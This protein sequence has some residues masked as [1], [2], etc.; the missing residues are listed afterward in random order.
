MSGKLVPKLRIVKC[1]K[2]RQLLQEP[3]GYDVYKCGGCGTDLQGEISILT[4]YTFQILLCCKAMQN[5][6]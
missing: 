2:C 4:F 6:L 1:P 3:Q 5:Q